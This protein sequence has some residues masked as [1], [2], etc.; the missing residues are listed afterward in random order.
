MDPRDSHHLAVAIGGRSKLLKAMFSAT[1]IFGTV[2]FFNGSSGRAN[3]FERAI[4][5]R[6][7]TYS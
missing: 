1:D 6:V 7:G 4:A 5:A 3:T 2:A